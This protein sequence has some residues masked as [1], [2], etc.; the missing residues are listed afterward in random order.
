MDTTKLPDAVRLIYFKA[1]DVGCFADGTYGHQHIR[2]R[3]ATEVETIARRTVKVDEVKDLL[4]S[5]RGEMSDD[6]SEEDEALDFLNSYAASNVR[7]EFVDGD[8]MLVTD[9]EGR[10]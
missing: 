7:F 1:K 4:A 8:L 10:W 2:E 3:L 5:L 9:D 6:A